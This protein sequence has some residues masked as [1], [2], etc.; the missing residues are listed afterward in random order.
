[1]IMTDARNRPEIARI[2]KGRLQSMIKPVSAEYIFLF[3]FTRLHSMTYWHWTFFLSSPFYT[4]NEEFWSECSDHCIFLFR[5]LNRADSLIGQKFLQLS[6]ADEMF[7]ILV[8]FVNLTTKRTNFYDD[9]NEPGNERFLIV[10]CIFFLFAQILPFAHD[11]CL[12]FQ[13]YSNLEHLKSC[14]NRHKL[15]KED[16]PQ[17]CGESFLIIFRILYF[18]SPVHFKVAICAPSEPDSQTQN[19]EIFLAQII[20]CNAANVSKHHEGDIFRRIFNR[21][22]EIDGHCDWYKAK[23][24]LKLNE[25][26]FAED[27]VPSN[28][29]KN[30]F[31]R[32]L[33]P[34]FEKSHKIMNQ[35]KRMASEFTANAIVV[36]T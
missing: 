34:D 8:A 28:R 36:T 35:L 24:F 19:V 13:K 11:L 14:S 2:V 30:S 15:I 3:V 16:G 27:I 7:G 18:Y 26:Y 1:M 6:M 25:I 10:C 22:R 20:P 21:M 12:E 5:G 23:I 17:L 4:E 9:S 32:E 31:I 33:Y 29:S